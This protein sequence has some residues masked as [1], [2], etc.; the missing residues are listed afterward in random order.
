MARRSRARARRAADRAAIA[1][2]PW[3]ARGSRRLRCA[4]AA[5]CARAQVALSASEAGADAASRVPLTSRDGAGRPRRRRPSRRSRRCA[6]HAATSTSS[7]S[8]SPGC[9]SAAVKHTRR[10]PPA[11]EELSRAPPRRRLHGG[12]RRSATSRRR[13]RGRRK[14][15][16]AAS[17]RVWRVR[18]RRRPARPAR[19]EGAAPAALLRAVCAAPMAC[20]PGARAECA[21]ARASP[22][23][24]RHAAGRGAVR[25]R[26]AS[27]GE[28]LTQAGR[29]G[30]AVARARA[31]TCVQAARRT[32]TCNGSMSRSRRRRRVRRSGGQASSQHPGRRS[33]RHAIRRTC[34][35]LRVLSGRPPVAFGVLR[36]Q[37]ATAPAPV[38]TPPRTLVGRAPA[39][40]RGRTGRAASARSRPARAAARADGTASRGSQGEHRNGKGSARAGGDDALERPPRCSTSGSPGTRGTAA[41][42]G[43]ARHAYER[44]R[45]IPRSPV[46]ASSAS[47]PARLQHLGRRSP[48]RRERNAAF[49]ARGAHIQH[50]CSGDGRSSRPV[51]PTSADSCRQARRHVRGCL[52]RRRRRCDSS[53][54][55]MTAHLRNARLARAMMCFGRS[56]SSVLSGR[57]AFGAPASSRCRAAPD[58]A[59][60]RPAAPSQG[61]CRSTPKASCRGFFARARTTSRAAREYA[62]RAHRDVRVDF[63]CTRGQG[64]GGTASAPPVIVACRRRSTARARSRPRTAVPPPRSAAPPRRPRADTRRPPRQKPSPTIARRSPLSGGAAQR[65][66]SRHLGA[67]RVGG[68]AERRRR[69]RRQRRSRAALAAESWRA[70]V[71]V[72]GTEARWPTRHRPSGGGA[73]CTRSLADWPARR[74]VSGVGLHGGVCSLDGDGPAAEYVAG[75][76]DPKPRGAMRD[77]F[78]TRAEI[79]LA[80]GSAAAGRRRGVDSVSV[81]LAASMIS[82]RPGAAEIERDAEPRKSAASGGDFRRIPQA[83]PQQTPSSRKRLEPPKHQPA[84]ARRRAPNICPRGPA[85]RAESPPSPCHFEPAAPPCAAARPC[86]RPRRRHRRQGRQQWRRIRSRRAPGVAAVAAAPRAEGGGGPSHI[87]RRGGERRAAAAA[88]RG[89][90]RPSQ[91]G[92]PGSATR[93]RRDRGFSRAS[94]L[95]RAAA[96]RAAAAT[97]AAVAV[98]PE[99]AGGGAVGA[100]AHDRGDGGGPGGGGALVEHERRGAEERAADVAAQPRRGGAADLPPPAR[101]RTTSFI[102]AAATRRT[103]RSLRN[104]RRRRSRA[105]PMPSGAGGVARRTSAPPR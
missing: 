39:G 27:C 74:S 85:W 90:E 83:A 11:C 33:Q 48:G 5:S 26:R 87:E 42:G 19:P 35:G 92:A 72:G 101:C 41:P 1:R 66:G 50:A 59:A 81:T 97:I 62:P 98:P 57:S 58:A 43:A 4:G 95:E 25:V 23:R 73:G 76:P 34:G 53:L 84:A 79:G 3:R 54:A 94:G 100:A 61:R 80:L 14:R 30:G 77:S 2:A 86:R 49:R 15:G 82:G 99:A 18:S 71:K 36:R 32:S 93:R 40:A 21:R 88:K 20:R 65:I 63:A 70:D 12:S 75:A 96:R 69:C 6:R 55:R 56:S 8:C 102:A 10:R 68:I 103:L 38:Q 105:P 16:A 46:I 64:G 52:R 91:A 67:G 60:R 13:R 28:Q 104:Q 44:A 17:S 37:R 78:A 47:R 24:E 9:R 45:R 22:A 51:S 29:R 89:R 7:R 31:S